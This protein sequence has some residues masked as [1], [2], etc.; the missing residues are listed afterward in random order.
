MNHGISLNTGTGKPKFLT[1][2][3]YSVQLARRTY[4]YTSVPPYSP[5]SLV[6]VSYPLPS[7]SKYAD[8]HSSENHVPRPYGSS[9]VM[10]MHKGSKVFA[11]RETLH[12]FLV[13][14]WVNFGYKLPL[15]AIVAS[16]E[17]YGDNDVGLISRCRSQTNNEWQ[18]R[19]QHNSVHAAVF[20][21]DTTTTA[22]LS[23]ALRCGLCGRI[24]GALLLG[25]LT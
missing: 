7:P 6:T 9:L 19:F 25:L 8:V 22:N 14:E 1:L 10:Y 15:L 16:P 17:L 11:G 3:K 2:I 12:D 20:A 24:C 5:P 21:T 23:W 4:I 13:T 18:W